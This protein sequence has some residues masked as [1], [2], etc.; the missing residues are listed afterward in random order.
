MLI[1]KTSWDKLLESEF[2]SLLKEKWFTGNKFSIGI[3]ISNIKFNYLGLQY[4][5]S[6]YL[7]KDQLTYVLAYYFAK[8]E[9]TKCNVIKF[10]CDS[11]IRSLIEKLL[12]KNA[13]EW[14]KKLLEISGDILEDK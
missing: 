6:F 10:L 2:L 11:S 5:N 3:S 12:N 9:T 7:F 8:S 13:N 4:K 1:K 14:I